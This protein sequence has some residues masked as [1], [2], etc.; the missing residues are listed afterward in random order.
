MLYGYADANPLRV[1]DR[2]GREP[3]ERAAEAGAALAREF[4]CASQFL[5]EAINMGRTNG[6]PW[7]HCWISCRIQ[8]EC[9]SG[10]A[11]SAELAKEVLDV[12]KC[13]PEVISDEPIQR[14]GNCAS[15][16]QPSDFEDNEFGRQC[17]ENKTCEEHCEPLATPEERLPPPGP[18][19]DIAVQLQQRIH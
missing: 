6:W 19:Y 9:P 12:I 17:P 5:Q 14:D 16:F 2:D 15:A 7:S 4:I 3:G 1:F 13:V 11:H 10:V 8:R 18:L